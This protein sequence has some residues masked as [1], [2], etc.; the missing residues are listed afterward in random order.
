MKILTSFDLAQQVAATI[1]PEKILAKA[2]G[3]KDPIRAAAVVR[4]G[5]IV[6]VAQNSSVIEIAFQHPD[7]TIVQPVLNEIITDYLNK[8]AEI[9]LALGTEDD[10]LTEETTQLRSQIAQTEREL[11]AAKTNF[12]II[13]IEDTKKTVGDQISKIEGQLL[14]AEVELATRQGEGWSIRIC[15]HRQNKR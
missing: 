15:R 6:G 4:S 10:S 11:M 7:P 9:H 12:G 3:G 8:Y 2:G 1:G 5:L 14:D 13:S